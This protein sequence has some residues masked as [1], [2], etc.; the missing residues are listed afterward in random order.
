MGSVHDSRSTLVQW[1]R[2]PRLLVLLDN[3]PDIC[4]AHAWSYASSLEA[5]RNDDLGENSD[6]CIRSCTF[7]PWRDTTT[8][9]LSV[10]SRV[11]AE[12]GKSRVV[13]QSPPSFTRV[14]LCQS[15]LESRLVTRLLVLSCE[16]ATCGGFSPF[17][18]KDL[19]VRVVLQT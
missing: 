7:Q 4:V 17:I 18:S 2:F 10:S 9:W 8:C 16:V 12:L 19:V 13:C 3:L 6:R 15:S 11:S 1:I 14:D 5:F